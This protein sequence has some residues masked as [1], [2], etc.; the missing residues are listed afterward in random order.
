MSTVNVITSNNT[1]SVVDSNQ[2][3]S[4]AGDNKKE[5]TLSV[6]QTVTNIVQ[7]IAAGPQGIPGP[8]G[9]PGGVTLATFNAYTSSTDNS[10]AGK[11]NLNGGNSFTGNQN[12]TKLIASDSVVS[13]IYQGTTSK[14]QIT[15]GATETVISFAGG[16]YSS[17]ILDTFLKIQEDLT[18][19]GLQT[20]YVIIDPS[21]PETIY[22]TSITNVSSPPADNLFSDTN[23]IY[24]AVYQAG[25]ILIKVQN[26]TGAG[27][28]DFKSIVR[29]FT[30]SG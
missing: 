18:L 21:N 28:L 11:A 10:I 16:L 8:Q 14:V 6:S 30:T 15:N 26:Q 1:I 29:S 3:I 2:T 17:L 22:F 7:V 25:D 9:E 5:H 13:P 12:I 4:I 20:V 23:V 24:T 27:T 19:Y